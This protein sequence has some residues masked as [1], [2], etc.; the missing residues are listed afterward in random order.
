MSSL[1]AC[2]HFL[3]DQE[4][5]AC[6]ER[7]NSAAAEIV[8]A[9]TS[10]LVAG[11]STRKFPRG[12]SEIAQ[13]AAGLLSKGFGSRSISSGSESL[14]T[15]G[16]TNN[17]AAFNSCPSCLNNT[18]TSRSPNNFASTSKI[19]VANPEF[20][21]TVQPD[22]IVSNI[23]KTSDEFGIPVPPPRRKKLPSQRSKTEEESQEPNVR[24]KS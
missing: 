19:V 2:E 22:I 18:T 16:L 5:I 12:V 15:S 10:E 24:S 7:K 8:E 13:A 4:E 9:L 21:A 23:V 20:S 14:S 1:A 17:Q 11:N 3:V 6:L